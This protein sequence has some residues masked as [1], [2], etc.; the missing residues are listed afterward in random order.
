MNIIL[1]CLLIIEISVFCVHANQTQAHLFPSITSQDSLFTVVLM[2]IMMVQANVMHVISSAN[3]S[4]QLYDIVSWNKLIIGCIITTVWKAI[5]YLL[6]VSYR[7]ASGILLTFTNFAASKELAKV[8][9]A[10][11]SMPHPPTCI[12]LIFLFRECFVCEILTFYWLSKVC[13]LESF[14]LYM[15]RHP[16]LGALIDL[17]IFFSFNLRQLYGH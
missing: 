5:F 7:I 16:K 17:H 15:R 3:I 13:T 4:H 9:S 10:K 6:A 11:F 8:F 2:I 14:L 12:R 1:C